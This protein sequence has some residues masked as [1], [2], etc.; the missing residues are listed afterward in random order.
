MMVQK[1]SVLLLLICLLALALLT[2]TGL[3]TVTAQD[4]PQAST[5]Y[6]LNM[7]SGPATTYDTL[8]V[9]PGGVA[10]FLEARNEDISWV[11]ART[12]DGASRGWVAS[13]Y[14]TYQPGFAASRLPVSSEIIGAPAPAAPETTNP[15]QA[16]APAPDGVTAF[17]SYEMNLRSGPAATFSALGKLPA[18]TGVILEARNGDASWVLAHT[19]DGSARGWLASL[20]LKFVG[21]SA[22]NLPVSSE[23]IAVSL[24]ETTG[25]A[26]PGSNVNYLDVP[27]GGYDPAKIAGIDLAAFPV[28][29]R[30]TARARE[31]FLAGRALGNSP[32]VLAKV[33][34]CSSEHW[35]F[36]SG[37]AWGEYNLGT[38]SSLLPVVNHFGESLAYDSQ[39]THN[40]FNV[41]AVLA[42]EWADPSVCQAGES[43][44]Q[45]EFR[46][47]KPSAVVIMFGTSDL[48][49][50]TPYEFDFYMRQIVTES[51]EAGVIP[52]LSTF[53]GNQ[54]FP[55]HTVLYNQVVVRIALDF[56]IP[57]INLWL[58]LE[59]LP[60]Q[61]LEADGFHLG[62]PPYG[63][64]CMLTAP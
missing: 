38:Y 39:A 49:V 33:G 48:L 13:L 35:Y 58:A 18:N 46:I 29:G 57:L 47:H 7:R 22:F 23:T 24:I 43:P 45:C 62:E 17:T 2:G 55:T 52:I 3:L 59:S 8:A 19:P 15:A 30:S 9:L 25:A 21:I 14:L 51:I 42:P 1:K 61:G 50:M 6:Q 53:P 32:N 34:D 64:A 36:L 37:F 16:A 40:G 12:A 28:V 31:I 11:L 60:N 5:T 4:G 41:N 10:L 26:I 27:M 63:T 54:G 56:D 20:Y 44:L